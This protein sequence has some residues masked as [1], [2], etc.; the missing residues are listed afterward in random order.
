MVLGS[1]IP[2]IAQEQLIFEQKG[3]PER[4]NA[5]YDAGGFSY[6]IV[7]D[8]FVVWHGATLT[9]LEVEGGYTQG[10]TQ[11]IGE[12]VV[13]IYVDEDGLPD[14]ERPMYTQSFRNPD[15]DMDGDFQL[16]FASVSLEDGEYWLCIFER[17]LETS[18]DPP[19]WAWAGAKGVSYGE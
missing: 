5:S 7:A 10:R 19:A 4:L 12:L 14:P 17:F 11:P 15:N 1:L 9:R 2:A 16:N 6:S 13:Q 3:D 18:A 8:D